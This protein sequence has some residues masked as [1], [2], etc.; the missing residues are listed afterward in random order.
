MMNPTRTSVY[1]V[2][3]HSTDQHHY[4]QPLSSSPSSS[5]SSYWYYYYY[6]YYYY[7]YYYRIMI[8]MLSPIALHMRTLPMMPN[9]G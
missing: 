6:Y 4:Y 8:P 3:I 7:H 2:P 9:M 1:Y 5:L